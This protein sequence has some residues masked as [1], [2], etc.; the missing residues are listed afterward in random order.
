MN[1]QKRTLAD[2]AA[3]VTGASK[4]L[5]RAIAK[6]FVKA[7]A[8]VMLVARN[9]HPLL[10]ARD[11]L[12]RLVNRPGQIV[13]AFLAEVSIPENCLAAVEHARRVFPIV[14]VLASNAGVLGPIG[15]L[16]DI[17]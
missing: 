1:S 16:D 13:E 2:R 4:G 9:E 15:R 5:G 14:R 6:E 8:S 3:V 7:G 17:D 10:R 11:D 12:A